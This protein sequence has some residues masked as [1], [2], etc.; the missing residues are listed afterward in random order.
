V[1]INRRLQGKVDAPGLVQETFLEGHRAFEQF[2]GAGER[3][4]V[5]WLRQV[6]AS[7]MA[8]VVRQ[9]KGAQSRDV[10]LERELV[11]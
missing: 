5:G 11:V 9:C 8:T 2:R 7:S 10:R 1:Q 4:L 6:L 3:E